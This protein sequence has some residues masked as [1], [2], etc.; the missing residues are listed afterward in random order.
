MARSDRN[1]LIA[2][3]VIMLLFGFGSYFM[4]SVMIAVGNVSTTASAGIAVLFV[5]GFFLVFWFRG[6][7]QRHEAAKEDKGSPRNADLER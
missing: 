7:S 5:A 6:R 2:A 4:P 3:A 1:A